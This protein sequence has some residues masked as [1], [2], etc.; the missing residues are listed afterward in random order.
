[1]SKKPTNLLSNRLMKNVNALTEFTEEHK[2]LQESQTALVDKMHELT[3][4]MDELDILRKS[5][6]QSSEKLTQLAGAVRQEMGAGLYRMQENTEV[7]ETIKSDML[8][9]ATLLGQ[10]LAL[11]A[12]SNGNFVKDIISQTTEASRVEAF[13]ALDG[14]TLEKLTQDLIAEKTKRDSRSAD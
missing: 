5:I 6:Q 2:M 4:G 8:D 14:E 1:M 10:K 9:D 11:L 7:L 13:A 12:Q 3:R